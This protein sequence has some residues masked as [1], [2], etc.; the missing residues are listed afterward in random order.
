MDQWHHGHIAFFD[1]RR[2]LIR[3]DRS[4]AD[5]DY[6]Y[7][8]AHEIGHFI[9]YSASS[10]RKTAIDLMADRLWALEAE[11]RPPE[12][13]DFIIQREVLACDL[14][15]RL[16]DDLRLEYPRRSAIVRRRRCIKS[17]ERLNEPANLSNQKK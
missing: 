9:D 17:Y 4:M 11:D 1:P 16:M 13:Q 5:L 2:K 8:L 15:E 7:A 10:E 12:L 6:V 3:V 14:G